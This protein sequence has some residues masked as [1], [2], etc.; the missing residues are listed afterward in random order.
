MSEDRPPPV[1]KE[2]DELPHVGTLECERHVRT[3]GAELRPETLVHLLRKSSGG[4]TT[5]FPICG[6]L[7]IGQK[8]NGGFY[9]GGHCEG[10]IMNLAKHYHFDSDPELLRDFRATCHAE[11][12]RAIHAGYAEKPFWEHNFYHCMKQLCIQVARKV[13]RRRMKTR[14]E[15][16][17]PES[18]DG[19]DLLPDPESLEDEI[20]GRIR[21]EDL[22]RMIR[23]LPDRQAVAALLA[24]VDERPIEGEGSDS[25]AKT[26]NVSPRAVYKLLSKARQRLL[27]DPEIQK[28]REEA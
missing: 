19:E 15:Q 8:G 5:L 26:M 16:A 12:W 9:T 2:I 11:M 28:Y 17:L 14:S 20:F 13:H 18:E 22:L 21:E 4:D 6:R 7:L 10:I 23:R 1:A 3:H 24:W 25:V 27:E